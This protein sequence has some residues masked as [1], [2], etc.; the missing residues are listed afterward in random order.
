M[1][2]LYQKVCYVSVTSVYVWCTMDDANI[3]AM[4]DILLKGFLWKIFTSF[5]TCSR[6]VISLPCFYSTYICY[7]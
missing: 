4:C 1:T 5:A 6:V 3:C 7:V 2:V